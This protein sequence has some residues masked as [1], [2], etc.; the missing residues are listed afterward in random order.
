M[1]MAQF[2]KSADAAVKRVVETAE[3]AQDGLNEVAEEARTRVKRIAGRI[4]GRSRRR[5]KVRIA[6]A[7]VGIVLAVAAGIAVSRFLTGESHRWR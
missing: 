7:A 5:R 6:A 2:K 3:Q 1:V 4:S